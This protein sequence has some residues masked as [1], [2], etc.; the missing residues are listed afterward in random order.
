MKT[1]LSPRALSKCGRGVWAMASRRQ[2][3][4]GSRSLRG[5]ARTPSCSSL[6]TQIDSAMQALLQAGQELG[7]QRSDLV[8]VVTALLDEDRGKADGSQRAPRGAEAC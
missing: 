1:A 4:G 3:G 8:E 5:W 6:P 7:P 2:C